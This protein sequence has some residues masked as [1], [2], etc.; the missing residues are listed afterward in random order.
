M[1]ESKGYYFIAEQAVAEN[2]SLPE[3]FIEEGGGGETINKASSYDPFVDP[4]VKMFFDLAQEHR[5]K[6]LLIQPAYRENQYLQYEEI[7]L[8]YTVLLKQYSNV[9]IAKEGWK[10]KF[11][12]NR[13]FSDP[14]HLNEEGARQYTEE[15]YVEF[16]EAFP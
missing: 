13:Y 8:Q 9:A 12:E 16:K 7:P 6:V 15:I 3:N 1:I 11:Y 14:T 4:Y 10:L 5:V 2:N